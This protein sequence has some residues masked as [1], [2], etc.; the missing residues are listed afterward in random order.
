MAVEPR[1]VDL[2]QLERLDRDAIV[3][4]AGAAY[5]GEVA[6]ALEQPVGDARGA[7]RALGD[8]A[9]AGR[10][11]LDAQDAGCLLYTSPSPRDRS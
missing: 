1:G 5:L 6:Y 2:E 11:D 3:D 10:L 4:A 9:G 7:A 8:R